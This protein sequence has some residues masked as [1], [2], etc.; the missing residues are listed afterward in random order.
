MKV[1][2]I[3]R[4]LKVFEPASA[5]RERLRK[6]A[7]M[8]GQLT[9][10]TFTRVGE[11]AQQVDEG[12]LKI[13]PTTSANPLF[14]FCDTYRLIKGLPKPDVITVQDPFLAGLAGLL[15]KK[16]YK[17]P[18]EIQV[19]TDVVAK[20]FRY[21]SFKNFVYSLL[22]RFILPR[23][24]KVRVVSHKL[25]AELLAQKWLKKQTIYVLP[26][27]TTWRESVGEPRWLSKIPMGKKIILMVGRLEKEKRYSLALQALAKLADKKVV[28][29]IAG[30]GS[31]LTKLQAEAVRLGVDK[32]VLWLG[33]LD[34]E[35]LMR[36]YEAAHFFLHTAAYEGYGLVFAEAAHAGLPIISTDVGVA[37]E[38][39]ALIVEPT[40]HAIAMGLTAALK[41][42]P[43]SK[44]PPLATEDDYLITLT[45]EWQSMLK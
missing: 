34:Q 17:A 13:I 24:N 36:S 1:L 3:G 4:D 15:A 12:A 32:Q 38:A 23:A 44:L 18:L 7:V 5:V 37:E 29:V 40:A 28:L 41:H 30:T 19:H 21:L 6:L 27:F 20:S 42:P 16:F 9:N 31:L 11:K 43:V 10:L 14:Y 26:I 22:A 45:R 35:E 25:K 8:V 2:M 33:Q 39:G